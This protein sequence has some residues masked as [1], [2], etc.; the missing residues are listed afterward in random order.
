LNPFGIGIYV[1]G[2]IRIATLKSVL[3]TGDYFSDF[4][5]EYVTR[6]GDFALP[7]ILAN[8]DGKPASDAEVNTLEYYISPA[9][10]GVWTIADEAGATAN[11]WFCP[12]EPPYPTG[13]ISEQDYSMRNAGFYV[14]TV[15]FD[16]NYEDPANGIWR[17]VHED[18]TVPGGATPS[19]EVTGLP[20]NSVT[21]YVWSL[22]ETGVEMANGTRRS[23]K[24]DDGSVVERTVQEIK[25]VAGKLQYPFE[26]KGKSQNEYDYLVLSAF[27]N[28]NYHDG[29]GTP[30]KDYLTV[31]VQCSEP[32]PP[33]VRVA[34]VDKVVTANSN[35]SHYVTELKVEFTQAFTEDVE[36]KITPSLSSDSAANWSDYIRFSDSQDFTSL[37]AADE[38]KVTIKAGKLAPEPKLY[39]FALR[40]D[41]KTVGI[42]NYILVELGGL[43]VRNVVLLAEESVF[44]GHA[45]F[46]G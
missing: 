44:L 33:S 1:S 15:D 29:S 37:P 46:L 35:Y 10:R 16:S 34:P 40:S 38:P 13:S 4:V 21:L 6:P 7:I 39:V 25:I 18:S 41:A 43:G 20:T 31:K 5:F 36:I 14:R 24:M 17:T 2:E 45:Q 8:K 27:P 42:G 22:N 19:I 32:L 12:S 11:F 30:L 28:F 3:S 26:I 9:A 23:I